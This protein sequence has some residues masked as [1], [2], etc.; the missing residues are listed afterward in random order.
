[1]RKTEIH[2]CHI[3]VTCIMCFL[4]LEL[5]TLPGFNVLLRL[6]TLLRYESWKV[7]NK[8]LLS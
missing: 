1:M 5:V 6:I 3:L 2:K 4:R 8:I 7:H